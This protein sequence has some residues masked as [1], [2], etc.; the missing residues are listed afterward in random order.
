MVFALFARTPSG[1]ISTMSLITAA[2][3][4]RSN[5]DSTRCLVTVFAIPFECLPS[6]YRAS[7]FPSHL[8]N[9]GMIPLKKKSQTRHIG[10]Q[11]PQLTII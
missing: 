2:L 11:N 10:D 7:K 8:S 3:S 5:Y 6:N 9:N 1:I 4:S